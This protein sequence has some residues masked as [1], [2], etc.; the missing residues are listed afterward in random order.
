[1]AHGASSHN[2]V[3]AIAIAGAFIN[4]VQKVVSREI[5]VD[6]GAIVTIGTIRGGNAPQYHLPVRCHGRDN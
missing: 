1:M 2:G 4:E 3:D 6:D 5:P